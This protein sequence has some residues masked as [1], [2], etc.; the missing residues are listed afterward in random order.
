M[1]LPSTTPQRPRVTRQ[2]V[3]RYAGVSSAVVSYVVNDGPK[4]VS[5]T[6]TAK[7]LNAVEALGYRPNAAARALKLGSAEML[8]LVVP[9]TTN[10][11]FAEFAHAVEEHAAKLG[12][13]LLT[14]N[15]ASSLARENRHL[16]NFHS[17]QVDG[18]VL[19]ST[20][21]DPD[22][23]QL[24]HEDMPIVLINRSRGVNGIPTIGVD[25]R[26]GAREGVQHLV[27]HNHRHIGL[28]VGHVSGFGPDQRELG[29]LDALAEANLPEGPVVRAP[30]DREGGYNAGARI[31]SHANRPTAVFV[32]SDMQAVG[33]MKA[34]HEA[35]L[36]VPD[37]VAIVSFDGSPEAEYSWPP[38]T[39]VKQPI[40]AM[41]AEAVAILTARTG[42]PPAEHHVHP[43]ELVLRRSCGC[44]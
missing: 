2:D 37:D 39:T 10:L 26:A 30:F 20:L 13:V 18:V 11:F 27:E 24:G 31:L 42:K 33:V 8:G 19:A 12:Y 41:A 32:S 3:A 16:R 9:D 28:V 4:R 5:P 40:R 7:V 17:R 25:L 23:L 44:S 15:S 43:V 38:L 34:A 14:A 1:E 36:S 29:W 6:T 21:E 35:G 22:P